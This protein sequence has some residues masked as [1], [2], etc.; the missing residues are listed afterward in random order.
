MLLFS[1]YRAHKT[2]NYRGGFR[3][4]SCIS[5]YNNSVSMET[6]TSVVMVT[7]HVHNNLLQQQ[8]HQYCNYMYICCHTH[9]HMLPWH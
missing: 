1:F 5:L 3:N 7:V 8:L 4:V 9:V 6:C 2:D